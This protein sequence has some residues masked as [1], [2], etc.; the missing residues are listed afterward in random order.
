M[1]RIKH[2]I[3]TVKEIKE[4]ESV[5][6]YIQ[7]IGLVLYVRYNN[8][9]HSTKMQSLPAPA[10]AD[11]KLESFIENKID[12]SLINNNEFIKSN[13]SVTYVGSQ[14]FGG[15]NITGVNDLTVNDDLD[16]DGETALDQVTIDTTDGPFAVS[17]ANN[18]TF[19]TTDISAN[20]KIDTAGKIDFDSVG[21]YEL[22]VTGDCDWHTAVTDWDNSGTFDLTSV[23]NVK[24]ETSGASTAK[25][26]S[27][28]NTN[29]PSAS[30]DG[31]H[32][33]A[34]SQDAV[35]CQNRILIEATSRASKGGGD[36]VKISSEDGIVIGAVDAENNDK[37]NIVIRATGNI[38][39]GGGSSSI[40]STIDTPYRVVLR[41]PIEIASLYKSD[42]DTVILTD[43]GQIAGDST[44]A[45]G[46]HTKFQA[47]DTT[48][49]IRATTKIIKNSTRL[50]IDSTCDTT[51][52]STTVTFT[53]TLNENAGL[54]SDGMKVTG[55]GI[56][57]N[58]IVTNKSTSSFQLRS[59]SGSSV[60]ANATGTNVSLSFFNYT[61]GLQS[62]DFILIVPTLGN[63][64][65]D[66]VGTMWKISINYESTGNVNC[67]QVWYVAKQNTKFAW[68]GNSN[69]SS[70]GSPPSSSSQG[71]VTWTTSN[72]IRWQNSTGGD[73]DNIRCS[74]LKIHS[75]TNDF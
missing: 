42:P 62:G 37:S 31:V 45:N 65:D 27:I 17:G 23:G 50:F 20:V 4:G 63:E 49:L 3:P 57:D 53:S 75:G 29:N 72:G 18:I 35:N 64:D 70:A 69:S 6:R 8:Q 10:I 11:K 59:T 32:I 14:S 41:S 74:A 12:D 2:G 34:D 30:F 40:S 15:N 55:P 61:N 5:Y 71:I 36:G 68:L 9:L 52:G 44:T 25:T 67:A 19:T 46:I 43:N 48:Q 38:D 7:G 21:K 24:I 73:V 66:A 54:I 26:I 13:G 51:S 39:I 33:K 58:S 47:I 60:N 16:V 22:N 56:P 28:F 1:A